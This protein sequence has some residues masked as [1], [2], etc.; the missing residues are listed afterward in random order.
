VRKRL[1]IVA[2]VIVAL[3]VI[4]AF[5]LSQGGTFQAIAKGSIIVTLTDEETGKP[6]GKVGSG[7]VRVVLGGIDQGYLTDKGELKI[8]GVE[9]G[10]RELLLVIPRYGEKRQFVEVGAG[11]TV[12]AN[13]IVDMPNPIFDVT[14]G[15]NTNFGFFDEYGDISV[16]LTNRGDADSV[17]TSVLV[18]VYKED[19]TSTP[20]A[21]HMLDFPSLVPRQD[22]GISHTLNWR[23]NE[24]V[25]GPKEIISAVVFD[26]WAYT[27]QNEQ[28]VSTIS[29]PSSLVAE[30]SY[31]VGNY[32]KSRPD[33]VVDT[34]SKILIG[35]FG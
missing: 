14:I 10:T 11:Q 4:A 24:F 26:G 20:I 13:V 1:V 33:L 16:T 3:I 6:I 9:A 29:A 28:V 19:D 21:T 5:L 31:S 18:I 12:P 30:I 7:Y 27:P 2:A 17:S 15:C 8:E 22:G 32:L 35:W 23:C 25:F 34:V